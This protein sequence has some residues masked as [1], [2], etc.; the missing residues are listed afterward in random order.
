MA[1]QSS[2]EILTDEAIIDY[3]RSEGR[4]RVVTNH[5]DINLNYSA[6]YPFKPNT[7][8]L[9]D[10]FFG[11]PF[12]DKCLCGKIDK[13]GPVCPACGYQ[14]LDKSEA[15]RRFARCELGFYYLQDTRFDIFME[16]FE[17][18]FAD[19]K[20]TLDFIGE[21][22]RNCNYSVRGGGKKLSIKTFDTCQFEYDPKKKELTISQ[23]ITE[24]GKCSYEGL[25][26]I[27]EDNFKDKLPDLRKLVNRYYLILPPILRPFTFNY[28]NGKKVPDFHE[29]NNWYRIVILLCCSNN[30]SA[31]NNKELEKNKLLNVL[32]EFKTP[33]EKARYIA[34]LRA[35]LNKGRFWSTKLLKASK[36]N[37]A[38]QSYAVR[39]KNS[40]RCPIIP[41]TTL[42]IDEVGIPRHIAYEMCRSGFIAY[43][44]EQRNFTYQ[45]AKRSTVEEYDNPELQKLFKEYAEKQVVLKNCTYLLTREVKTLQ[46]IL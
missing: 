33:G 11:S 13:P 42:A 38:R 24:L 31:D 27:F 28:K 46:R 21:D 18:V 5:K 39:T 20:I 32:D 14:V 4:D 37:L 16:L 17:D 2:I 26:K 30:S 10:E 25:L 23:A 1:T 45:E 6:D 40:A 12:E 8:G 44:Q 19:S 35:M 34:L 22:F 43:L 41:S 9:F 3:T 7:G 15:L 36:E 29:L